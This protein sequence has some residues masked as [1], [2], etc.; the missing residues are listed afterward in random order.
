MV[1]AGTATAVGMALMNERRLTPALAGAS[2]TPQR[3]V[4]AL[5]FAPAAAPP[6]D[7]RGLLARH[8]SLAARL[9]VA[10]ILL[11]ALLPAL[12][13]FASSITSTQASGSEAF[14]PPMTSRAAS[15]VAG[16]FERASSLAQPSAEDLGAVALA[17]AVEQQKLEDGLRALAA[18]RQA[19]LAPVGRPQTLNLPSGYA[20]GTILRARI[21]IYGCTG[22]GGG[23]CGNMATGVPVFEGAAA[24]SRDLPFGTKIRI[25]GDPT[26]RT[27]EC[28]DRGALGSTWVDV[29][30]RDTAQGIAW[31]GMLGGTMADIEIVN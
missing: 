13:V 28:L 4:R 5:T 11:V 22:P 10:V 29:F 26:G 20:V 8:V 31:Q 24:C 1:V 7:L 23:F 19:A 25:I 3:S 15:G 21:T 27:Y 17:A 6:I 2:A 16:S 18:K 9:A 14:G 30:F 12:T